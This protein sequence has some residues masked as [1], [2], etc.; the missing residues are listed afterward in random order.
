MCLRTEKN[1]GSREMEEREHDDVLP[2]SDRTSHV[3]VK[4]L[5]PSVM[6]E[7]WVLLLFMAIPPSVSH[8]YNS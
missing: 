1:S 2:K 6:G 7:I 3:R 8:I 4:W 5:W